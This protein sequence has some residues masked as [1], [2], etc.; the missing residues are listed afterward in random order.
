MLTT[1][2]ATLEQMSRILMLLV[3]GFSLNKF[4]IL[5]KETEGIVSKLVTMLFLPCLMLYTNMTEC[6]LASLTTYGTLVLAGAGLCLGSILLSYP[7]ARLLGGKDAFLRGV[8]RYALSFPN[9]GAVATP[10]VLAFFGTAGLFRF[11]LFWFAAMIA[12]YTWG[13]AQMQPGTQKVSVWRTLLKCL[14]PTTVAMIVGLILGILGV[15]RWIPSIVTGTIKELG[16]CY[17]TLGILLAGFTIA[18]YPA[19]QV[20]GNFRVY[21]YAAI[22][23]LGL[24]L[25][26]LAVLLLC[27]ASPELCTMAVLAFTGPC[28]MNAVLYPAAY[29]QDCRLGAS[30]VLVSSIGSV[31]TIPLIYSLSQYLVG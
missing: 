31:V 19:G 5:P 8:Y 27:K 17:V 16:N 22:R 26:A 20:L 21:L 9:T 25:L 15:N 24:P 1:F 29:G 18:D 30:I 13:I 7:V 4:R 3:I 23:L 10:L 2:L 28:G 12:T 6:Q 11:N 14:N